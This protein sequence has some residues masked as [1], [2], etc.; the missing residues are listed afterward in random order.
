LTLQIDTANSNL[1][2]YPF[3]ELGNN[4]SIL[5]TIK[6]D[7]IKYENREVGIQ[8]CT[9]AVVSDKIIAMAYGEV[10]SN[11]AYPKGIKVWSKLSNSW[12]TIEVPWLSKLIGWMEED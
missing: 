3:Y 11:L 4:F 8:W 9:N 7:I 12:T 6:G 5:G 1:V 2:K 10:G